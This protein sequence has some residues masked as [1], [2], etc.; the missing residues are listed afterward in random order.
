MSNAIDVSSLIACHEC[1]LLHHQTALPLGG[2]ACCTRCGARL[3]ANPRNSLDRA[4]ALT[5]AAVI[6]FA[7]VNFFPIVGLDAQ[8]NLSS[9]TMPGSALALYKADMASVAMLVFATTVL[10]PA[11]Y[12]SAMLYLLLPYKFGRVPP[13]MPLVLRA[14]HMLKHWG[15][16]EVYLLGL[17]AALVK[18]AHL[19]AIKPGPGMWLLGLLVFVLAAAIT[20]FDAHNF[21]H[22]G[23]TT[24]SAQPQ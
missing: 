21:W 3:Y 20:A 8:G 2:V 19:A 14:V 23:E 11:A 10:A 4:L 17:L 13:M 7:V 5:L 15:M 6:L 22:V 16:V 9:A 24:S 18:L 12:L 1:D